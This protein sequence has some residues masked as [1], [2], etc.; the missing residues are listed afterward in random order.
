[1]KQ[2]LSSESGFT[3]VEIALAILVASI[4]LLAVF[5]LFPA[6]LKLNKEAIDETQAAMFAEEVFSGFKAQAAITDWD[7]LDD[8]VIRPRSPDMWAY[9]QQQ[10]IEA[11]EGWQTATY[12]PSGFAGDAVD[13]AVRYNLRVAQ[14]VDAD[15]SRPRAYAVLEVLAGEFGPTNNPI[16][17]YTEILNTRPG[18]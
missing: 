16:R 9:T 5:S 13:F 4:G 18:T 14:R 2:N 11:N 10:E 1:M 3:L 8:I 17:F 15:G 7:E 6:G 12:R